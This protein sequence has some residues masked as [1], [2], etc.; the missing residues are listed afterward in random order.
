MKVNFLFLAI[1]LLEPCVDNMEIFLIFGLIMAI[2]NLIK[3]MILAHFNFVGGR[4][5][6][7]YIIIISA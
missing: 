4:I 3:H 1:Y 5:L 7:Q 2:E 6:A